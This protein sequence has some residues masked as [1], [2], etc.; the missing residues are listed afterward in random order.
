VKAIYFV[1]MP[2]P[3][4]SRSRWQTLLREHPDAIAAGVCAVLV[5]LGWLSLD[6]VWLGVSVLILTAAYV[7]GGYESTG[8]GLTTLWR[9][10][11]LDVDLLMIVAALGAAGL[12]LWRKE[13]HFIVDGGML[14][15]IFAISGVLEGYAIRHTER[16]I[17]GLMSLTSD[18]ARKLVDG[19]EQMVAVA[20]LQIGDRVLVK[21]GELVPTD[22]IVIEG[23]SEL[24]Q[25][26]IT[27]E[28]MP[29]EKSVGDEVFAGT[30]NGNGALKIQI[31]RQKV[32]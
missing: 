16:S 17:Q 6:R 8:E 21:P 20:E 13:H 10:K 23:L 25:A 12:G 9:E 3:S 19:Q 32:V 30:I 22:G 4:L 26:P 2:F 14:I 28:S 31:D 5:L 7:I 24:N 11:E 18:T 27:G 1:A 15:L 29:V